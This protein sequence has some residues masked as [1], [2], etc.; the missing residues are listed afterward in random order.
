MRALSVLC[1]SVRHYLT[2]ERAPV[3]PSVLRL[4]YPQNWSHRSC[5]T[6]SRCTC[7]HCSG[8]G[9]IHSL[10]GNLWGHHT[11]R[12]PVTPPQRD[13]EGKACNTPKATCA[14]SFAED[15]ASCVTPRSFVKSM[16][17]VCKNLPWSAQ[18]MDLLPHIRNLFD[19]PFSH[20]LPW[21]HRQ[22]TLLLSWVPIYFRLTVSP[23]SLPCAQLAFAS[24]SPAMSRT[25]RMT[26]WV[27]VNFFLIF[28]RVLQHYGYDKRG[29]VEDVNQI[30]VLTSRVQCKQLLLETHP[31]PSK[32]PIIVTEVGICV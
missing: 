19:K 14:R 11:V 2:V 12:I 1:T 21:D 24:A 8:L 25:T 31:P 30:G 4:R 29:I 15:C 6:V 20:A 27:S 9:Q 13:A 3:D 32:Y 10:E 7:V 5:K 16:R 22:D 26:G 18:P 17:S 23:W 28:W